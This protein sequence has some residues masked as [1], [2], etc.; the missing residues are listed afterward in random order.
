MW[1]FGMVCH[2]WT[3]G[4]TGEGPPGKKPPVGLPFPGSQGG[5]KMLQAERTGAG[6]P[7]DP[8]LP[9]WPSCAGTSLPYSASHSRAAP[10]LHARFPTGRFCWWEEWWADGRTS[11]RHDVNVRIDALRKLCRIML[12][13][14][15]NCDAGMASIIISSPGAIGSA[16]EAQRSEPTR[17]VRGTASRASCAVWR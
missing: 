13:R 16:T 8:A 3:W 14:R 17:N 6:Y 2:S 15:Y 5:G 1:E 12:W 9:C 7:P 4:G 11:S 10:L